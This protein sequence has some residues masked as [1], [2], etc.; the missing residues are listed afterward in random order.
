VLLLKTDLESGHFGPSGRYEGIKE[1]AFDYA[2][3]LQALNI[4][5]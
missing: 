3:L 5:R 4:Q 2:F 1:T